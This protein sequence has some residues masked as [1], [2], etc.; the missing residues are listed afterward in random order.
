MQHTE[1]ERETFFTD[2]LRE[3][4]ELC[5]SDCCFC[6]VCIAGLNLAQSVSFEVNV[7]AD[8]SLDTHTQTSD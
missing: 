1:W 7:N 2:K 4:I 6:F 8:G 3:K 5:V